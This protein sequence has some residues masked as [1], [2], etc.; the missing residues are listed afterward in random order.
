VRLAERHRNTTVLLS[1]ISNGL[2]RTKSAQQ[3]AVIK[4]EE[5]KFIQQLRDYEENAKPK[6][7]TGINV[8]EV[9]TLAD[10]W[11]ML[12]TAVDEYEK[13]KAAGAWGRVRQAFRGLGTNG[14]AV[15]QWLGLLPSG[16]NYMSVVCGGVKLIIKAGSAIIQH[17]S[18]IT[19]MLT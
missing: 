1:Y 14:E 13:G 6:Y 4:E 17:Q 15:Q 11:R 12:D 16:S 18:V 5:Q 7:R 2:Y 19:G 10:V 3:L 9:H 8:D